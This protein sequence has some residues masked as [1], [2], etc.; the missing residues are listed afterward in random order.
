MKKNLF[1]F[2]LAGL[3]MSCASTGG[4]MTDIERNSESVIPNSNDRTGTNNFSGVIGSEWKL[5]GVSVNGTDTQFNRNALSDAFSESFTLIFDDKMLSGR[6]APNQYSAPYT[7][8]ENRSISTLIM[9]TTLM[10][11]LFEPENLKEYD[12]FRYMQYI[13]S[14]QLSDG[15]LIL[16]S[17][18]DDGSEVKLIFEK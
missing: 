1:L 13:N 8:G 16:S 10:A 14:W 18:L 6:G 2:L 9:R 11:S 7:L 4:N 5:T 17:L 12:Y 15:R 3:I